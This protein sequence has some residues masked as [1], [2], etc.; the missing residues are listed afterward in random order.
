[1][2]M[3]RRNAVEI[4]RTKAAVTRRYFPHA[5]KAL[6]SLRRET[7]LRGRNEAF[8]I[9]MN[10]WCTPMC[11]AGP[12]QSTMFQGGKWFASDDPGR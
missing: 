9:E 7:Q 10:S 2:N 3:I 11:P 6:F 4:Q 12:G 8:Q 5:Q 1:M